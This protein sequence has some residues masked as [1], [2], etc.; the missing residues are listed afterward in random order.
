M[1]DSAE[2]AVEQI[3]RQ[4]SD[5]RPPPFHQGLRSEVTLSA[6]KLGVPPKEPE[7]D[8]TEKPYS[9]YTT[10]EKWFIVSVASLA[11]LFR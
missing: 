1:G 5:D 11:A 10:S 4:R 2:M 8:T 9:I 6:E 3:E 7:I